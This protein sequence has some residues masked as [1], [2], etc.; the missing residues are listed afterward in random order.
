MT[1]PKGF[2]RMTKQRRIILDV[3]RGT[4]SHPT[5]DWIYERVREHIPNVSLGTVYRNL[6]ILTDMGEVL[7]LNYGSTHS[8]YDGNTKP[9]YHFTC[10]E[11]GRCFDVFIDV[12]EHLEREVADK[13][14]FK[15]DYHRLEFYGTCKECQETAAE[16]D[17][18]G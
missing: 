7:E 6:K 5:A 2:Q 18:A 10:E 1:K 17:I 15:V 3:L 8:R 12:R 9:H 4:T 14:G 16:E 11:C 13:T